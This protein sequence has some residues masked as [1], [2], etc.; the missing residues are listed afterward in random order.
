MKELI[1]DKVTDALL[2]FVERQ[3]SAVQLGL[4][5]VIENGMH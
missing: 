5:A 1:F 2:M 4:M 3:S